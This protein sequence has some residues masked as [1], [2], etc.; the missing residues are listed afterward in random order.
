MTDVKKTKENSKGLGN[1]EEKTDKH[2]SWKPVMWE[3]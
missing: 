3:K 1:L 2:E